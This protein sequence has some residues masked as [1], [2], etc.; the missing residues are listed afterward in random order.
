MAYKKKK[1]TVTV[2]KFE[3][4]KKTFF[5]YG[6]IIGGAFMIFLLSDPVMNFLGFESFCF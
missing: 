1:V 6:W 4:V 2:E 3:D 5:A